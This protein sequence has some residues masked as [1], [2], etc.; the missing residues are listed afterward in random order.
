MGE[1]EGGKEGRRG[2]VNGCPSPHSCPQSGLANAFKEKDVMYAV[3]C[4][5]LCEGASL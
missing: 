1:G 4:L 3:H 2:G 5:S